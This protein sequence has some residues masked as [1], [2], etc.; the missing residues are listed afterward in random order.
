MKD[1]FI[2]RIDDISFED[3]VFGASEKEFYFKIG[4]YF[5]I[6]SNFWSQK[7]ADEEHDLEPTKEV[8]I[9]EYT[10]W[11]FQKFSHILYKIS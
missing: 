3:L 1:S 10:T 6:E 4:G 7:M 5:I 2:S 9:C 11:K 8:R